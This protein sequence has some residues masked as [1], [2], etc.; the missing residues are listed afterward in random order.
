MRDDQELEYEPSAA[1]EI[2]SEAK[3]KLYAALTTTVKAEIEALREAVRDSENALEKVLEENADLKKQ[4]ESAD[5]LRHKIRQ[6][7]IEEYF[8]DIRPWQPVW[9]VRQT[10]R[11]RKCD[12]C[13]GTHEVITKYDGVDVKAK[14]PYCEFNGIKVRTDYDVYSRGI[15]SVIITL[16]ARDRKMAIQ[17]DGLV[18]D[19]DAEWEKTVLFDNS[20]GPS[21]IYRTREAAE[22]AIEKL[23]AEDAAEGNKCVT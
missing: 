12:H 3:E 2:F 10:P 13:G 23:K 1:D 14:C 5:T 4:I 18:R 7:I 6:E 16:S 17:V 21:Y 20:S 11:Y 15:E 8:L 22:A 19:I 9:F